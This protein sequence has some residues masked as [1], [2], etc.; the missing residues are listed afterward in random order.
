MLLPLALILACA[1]IVV[2]G[3]VWVQNAGIRERITRL[4]AQRNIWSLGRAANIYAQQNS[5]TAAPSSPVD[6]QDEAL[7]NH[8][9]R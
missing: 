5:S 4:E 3:I 8:D 6:S 2:G 7:D 9:D 1:G